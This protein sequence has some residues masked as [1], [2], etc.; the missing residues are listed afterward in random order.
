MEIARTRFAEEKTAVGDR[1]AECDGECISEV[2]E[3]GRSGD[4]V[5]QSRRRRRE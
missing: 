5:A 2:N 1:A 4:D 3:E